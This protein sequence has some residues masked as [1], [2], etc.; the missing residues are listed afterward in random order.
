MTQVLT[1]FEQLKL[2]ITRLIQTIKAGKASITKMKIILKL[3]N[4]ILKGSRVYTAEELLLWD[5]YF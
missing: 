1:L 2:T 5:M 3:K 4:R